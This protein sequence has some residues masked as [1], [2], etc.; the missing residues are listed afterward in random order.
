[1][2]MTEEL[3]KDAWWCVDMR[4]KHKTTCP[5][6]TSH[7]QIDGNGAW[8]GGTWDMGA[9]GLNHSPKTCHVSRLAYPHIKTKCRQVEASEK[10]TS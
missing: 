5:D 4:K 3:A 7:I 9:C 1:M 2:I 10:W 8:M 6:V